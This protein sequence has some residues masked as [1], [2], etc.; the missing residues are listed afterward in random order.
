MRSP[1]LRLDAVGR[2]GA[3]V[4]LGQGKQEHKSGDDDAKS[5][6]CTHANAALRE[7]RVAGLNEGGL[8][9]RPSSRSSLTKTQ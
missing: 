2:L 4:P 7:P 5:V 9:A 8:R 6:D 1:R 3:S